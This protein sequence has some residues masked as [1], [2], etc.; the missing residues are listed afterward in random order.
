MSLIHYV[1]GSLLFRRN[2]ERGLDLVGAI[3]IHARVVFHTYKT[4]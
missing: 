4:K 1:P 2:I 3:T